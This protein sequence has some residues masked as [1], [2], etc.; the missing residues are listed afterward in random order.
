MPSND[1]PIR[2]HQAR[3]GYLQPDGLVVSPASLVDAQV[4]LDRNT[5]PLQERFLPFV[6][7][8]ERNGGDALPTIT[9][10]AT[11]ACD[12]L[13]WPEDCLFGLNGD[14][15]IPESLKVAVQEG[16]TLSPSLAFNDPKPKDS[17]QPWLLLVQ[18]LQPDTDL[19]VR[20]A[21][22]DR[23]WSASPHQRF[24]RLLRGTKVPIG[25]ITNGAELRLIYAPHGETSGSI[26]FPVQ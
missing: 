9:D 13:E 26:T 16:E 7:E 1:S 5:L 2:D 12:F 14:L 3:L 17:A 20:I 8:V 25:L 24:E 11:F 15:P 6:Q 22:D 19:D 21:A 23:A 10:F 18:I 4:L